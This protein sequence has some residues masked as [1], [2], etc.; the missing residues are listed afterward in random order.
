VSSHHP[1]G[2]NYG[3]KPPVVTQAVSVSDKVTQRLSENVGMIC[4]DKQYDK[5]ENTALYTLTDIMKEFALE[6]GREMKMNSEVG[7]RSEVNMIDAL[8]ASYEY[9]Y[10]KELQMDH[11]K[12]NKLSFLPYKHG[13]LQLR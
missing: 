12:N 3:A 13:E 5:I 7:G 2:K 4:L 11:I 6:I 8:N 10:T 1:I 9:G